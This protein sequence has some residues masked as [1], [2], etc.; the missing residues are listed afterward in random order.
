[1]IQGLLILNDASY[2]PHRW[3]GT[4]LAI[5]ISAIATFFNTYGAKHLPTLEGIILILHIFG[6]FAI[7]IPLWVLAPRNTADVVF[8]QFT[9]GGGWS[10][11]GLAC[12]VGM[13]SPIY[14]FV[15]PDSA[16]HM[17]RCTPFLSFYT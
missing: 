6:F 15:G 10:S 7:L 5:A 4:L 13:I 8:T 14:A 1:M 11:I 17:G 3:H 12:L 16:T 2:V 9:N